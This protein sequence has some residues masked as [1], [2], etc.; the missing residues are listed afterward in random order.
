MAPLVMTLK[1][2]L[3]DSE[4]FWCPEQCAQCTVHSAHVGKWAHTGGCFIP[5]RQ[6]KDTPLYFGGNDD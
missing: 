2:A 3:P 6:V 1:L 4:L 5:A